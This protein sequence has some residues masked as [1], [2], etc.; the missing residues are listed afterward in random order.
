MK[1]VCWD[2]DALVALCLARNGQNWRKSDNR[3][4]T[5][6]LELGAVSKPTTGIA[7]SRPTATNWI[8]LNTHRLPLDNFANARELQV[9]VKREKALLKAGA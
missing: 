8:C 2:R 1:K 7:S 5:R 9:S 6:R 3:L 4:T